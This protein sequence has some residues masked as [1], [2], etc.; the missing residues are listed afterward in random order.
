M[1]TL[2]SGLE[3]FLADF[4]KRIPEEI[5]QLMIDADTKLRATG[6]ERQ[7][8]RA[9]DFAPDFV[10]QGLGAAPVRLSDHLTRG[11]VILT[12]YR[13]GWCPYCNLELRAY[14]RLMPD[15][16]AAGAQVIAVS[17]Q[18]PDAS[19]AT[20]AS[21]DLSFDVVSDTGSEVA[22]RFGLAFELPAPLKALYTRFGHPLPQ[23]NGTDD[24]YLPVPG[25]FVI[26]QDRRIRL[27]SASIDY[28]ARLEP[29]EALAALRLPAA[30]FA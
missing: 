5:R 9:G 2:A 30:P 12:F 16:R 7:I 23:I 24:W 6:I 27:S 3:S 11:P 18:T 26:G 28:R 13:G 14:E 19:V 17:P 10:L 21:N 8:L 1:T 29:A 4:N 15:I 22:R 20:V 25:T